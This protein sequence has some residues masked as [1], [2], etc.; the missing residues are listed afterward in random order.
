MI[1]VVAWLKAFVLTQVVEIPIAQAFFRAHEPRRWRRL[2]LC[3]IATLATHPLVWFVFPELGLRY[4]AMVELA[5]LWAW[6]GEAGFFWLV[7]PGV[8]IERALL[9]SG[10]A[11]AASLATVFA[12][13][14]VTDWV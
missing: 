13:R 10:L 2:W 9:A 8:R 11:N 7:F 12:L 3:G 4:V 6:L 14:A 5:E 1:L